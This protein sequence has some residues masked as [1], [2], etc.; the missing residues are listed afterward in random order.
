[1]TRTMVYL[2]EEIHRRLKH[3]AVER[4][5][6]LTALIREAVSI[7]Y[8]EDLEDVQVGRTRRQEYLKHPERVIP[9]A[10]YRAQRLAS[11]R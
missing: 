3:L 2:N 4:H 7:Q 5:T 11:G 1:M 8:R 10:S 9:Y 6:S